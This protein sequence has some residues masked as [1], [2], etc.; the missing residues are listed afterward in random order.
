M[1]IPLLLLHWKLNNDTC[2]LTEIEKVITRKKHNNNTFI[3]SILGP[4]YEPKSTTIQLLCISLWFI[5]LINYLK[6]SS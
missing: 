5:S 2:L 3:G 1:A 4:I 6:F